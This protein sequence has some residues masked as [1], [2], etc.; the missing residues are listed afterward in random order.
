MKKLLIIL[1]IFTT[2][3]IASCSNESE[4]RYVRKNANSAEAQSDIEAMEKAMEIM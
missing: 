1:G 3:F 2:L 4:V